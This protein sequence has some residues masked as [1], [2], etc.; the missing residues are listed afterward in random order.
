MNSYR[1]EKLNK[2]PTVDEPLIP[3]GILRKL[4][5]RKWLAYEM[6]PK[7]SNVFNHL[8]T[9]ERYSHQSQSQT[10]YQTDPDSKESLQMRKNCKFCKKRGKSVLNVSNDLQKYIKT[11]V[12]LDN[13]AQPINATERMFNPNNQDSSTKR[14]PENYVSPHQQYKRSSS[15]P[16]L[17]K[18]V[19]I[20]R[21]RFPFFD[22]RNIYNQFFSNLSR[23]NT[24]NNRNI[25]FHN[26]HNQNITRA[27]LLHH[28]TIQPKVSKFPTLIYPTSFGVTM[29]R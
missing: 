25:I 18:Q 10:C 6:K 9:Q 27:L 17:R 26:S 1:K 11:V 21:Q 15:Q 12:N 24:P 19:S 22:N 5:N 28:N 2:N 4:V 23:S 20:A 8:E 14:A 13:N 3:F 29:C 7:F 16:P